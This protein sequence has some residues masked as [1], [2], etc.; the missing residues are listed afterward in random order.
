MLNGIALGTFDGIHKGHRAVIDSIKDYNRIAVT[1]KKPPKSVLSGKQELLMTPE[2]KYQAL[3]N[4][5]V[6]SVF[7]PEFV[8]FKDLS[9]KAFLDLLSERYNPKAIACGFNY[10]FGKNALGDTQFLFEYCKEKGIKLFVCDAVTV[11]GEV[12]SSSKIRDMIVDGDTETANSLIYG[13]FSFSAEVI[14]GDHRGR[15][16]GFPTI[17]QIYPV[18]LVK[19]KLGVYSVEV[20]VENESYKAITNLGY[21]PTFKTPVVTAE[22]Y[23]PHFFG[24][25]YGKH[26]R[27]KLL[28]YLREEHKFDSVEQL[29]NAINDDVSRLFSE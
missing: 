16:I 3:L 5:G 20:E 11:D 29:K 1:F 15:T 13:G 6:N 26:L 9:P 28:R 8:E 27:I 18:C 14:H 4:Y 23:I 25:L 10:R 24:D 17:N 12:V 2:D 21:R 19:P 22:T 7:M